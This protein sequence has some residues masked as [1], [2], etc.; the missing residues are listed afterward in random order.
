MIRTVLVVCLLAFLPADIIAGTDDW[1]YYYEQLVDELQEDTDSEEAEELSEILSA[2]AADPVNINAVTRESLE[3][4]LFLSNIQIDAIIDYVRRYGPLMSKAELM[5]IPFLDDIRC[6]LLACLS[7]IGEMPPREY[8]F[9]DSLR[10]EYAMKENKDYFSTVQDRGGFTAYIKLPFYERKGD[11]SGY[12]GYKYKHWLRFK[13]NITNRIKIGFT[14][15]QDAGEPFFA[16]KN[17]WGYDYYS[18][19]IQLQ[20]TGIIKN[21]V[22]GHYRVKTGLGLIMNNNISFGKTFGTASVQTTSSVI[23]PHSSRSEGN[24]LQGAALTLGVSR[25]VDVTLFGSYRKIDATLNDTTSIKTIVKTGYHRTLSELNRKHNAS[26]AA[27]GI[28]LRYSFSYFNFGLTGI[29]NHYSLPLKPYTEGSSNSQLYR[30]FY[31]SGQDFWNISV[32]YGYK[33]GNRLRIEG[34][35]GTGDCGTVA[36]LNTLSWRLGRKLTLYTVYRYYPVKF[37]AVSGKSF[38]EGGSNQDENGL[39]ISA[40]WVPSEYLSLSAY[41]DFAYF[42]WPKYLALGSSNSFDN[43]LQATFKLSSQSSLTARY[44]LKM[45][46]KNSDTE[47]ILIYK[48]EHRFRLAYSVDVDKLSLRSRADLSYCSY[49]DKSLGFMLSQTAKYSMKS[50]VFAAGCG[51]FNTKDYNSRIYI[52][53]QSLPSTFSSMSFYGNGLRIYCMADVT[54]IKNLSITGRLGFTRYF[55][56]NEIGS[57]YQTIYSSSQTDLEIMLRYKL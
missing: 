20:K 39:Y 34:E 11:K 52:Y 40:E 7:Y 48:N 51:Y 21:L 50:C 47:G 54:L 15:S 43:F 18:G 17:K 46:Q 24:Y 31:P 32:N 56:R 49:K 5:M 9:L 25:N 35:T 29:Y 12:Y 42:K 3:D 13:Y 19:F 8:N 6:N 45:R 57:S 30:F 37:Y 14:A 4:L 16:N 23:H 36:T 55:D 53:E 44:R 22:A 27:A 2:V 41:T 1:Q 38:S 26:Q 33:L 28:Y 10:Y